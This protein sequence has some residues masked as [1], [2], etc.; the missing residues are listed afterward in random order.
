[1]HLINCLVNMHME[2]SEQSLIGAEQVQ[3]TMHTPASSGRD[4]VI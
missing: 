4:K 2:E 3:P 1:M